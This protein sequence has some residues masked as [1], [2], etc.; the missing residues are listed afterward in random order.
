MANGLLTEYGDYTEKGEYRYMI[1][2]ANTPGERRTDFTYDARYF[3]LP[4]AVAEPSILSGSVKL[5]TYT[6]DDSGNRTSETIAGFRPDGTPVARMTTWKYGGPNPGDCPE[7]EAPF[8]QLCEIDGPRADVS[9]ITKYRYW[10]FDPN[11]QTHSTDDGRLKEVEDANGILIRHDIHYTPTGKIW[12]ESDANN[13]MTGYEYYPGNDRLK[14]MSVFGSG[15]T[16]YTEWTYLATGEVET[17]TTAHGSSDATTVTFSYD[18]ARRLVRVTNAMG[19]YIKYTLDTEGNV[20]KEEIFDANGTPADELDDVLTKVLTRVFDDYNRPDLLKLGD[21]PVN[22]LEV[23]DPFNDADGTVDYSTNGNGITT[24]YSYDALKRLLASTQDLNGTDP[25]TANARTQYDYDVADRLTEVMDPNNGTTTYQYDDLGNLISTTSPDTGVTNYT[26]DEAGNVKSKTTA[27]GTP[28]ALTLNYSYDAM[29]RLQNV[30]APDPRE[31]ITYT[32]DN[33]PNGAGRLCAVTNGASTVSYS[34]DSFGNVATHQGMS[35][36]YDLASR[37]RT[38]TYPSGAAVTYGYDP[39]GQISSV[40]LNIN[41]QAQSLASNITY[42]PFGGIETLTYGN[43]LALT[44]Q[45][46]TA[47]RLTRQSIPGIM[48]LDYPLYDGNGNLIQ[49][50]DST[51][52]PGVIST[53]GYDALDRLDA[54]SGPFASGWGYGYD[55]NGNRKQ[56]NEAVSIALDYEPNSNRLDVMGGADVIL[57]VAGNTLGIGGWS[58]TYTPHYRLASAS[59][60]AVVVATYA[61]NGLGQRVTKTRAG[62]GP[63]R[64][65]Y[66]LEGAL[67]AETDVAGTALKEYVYLN[68]APLAL[69][70]YDQDGDGVYQSAEWVLDPGR[71]WQQPAR[72]RCRRLRQSLRCRFQSE[73]GYQYN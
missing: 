42:S 53:F 18:D 49:R 19:N 72:R 10:P 41:G 29:N 31:N 15:G 16:Q 70:D 17:I 55:K 48:A 20:E 12:H 34:Y 64:F 6:Y 8:H 4:A 66:G 44:Q 35:Y 7:S 71:R 54:A 69:I 60:N 25:A 56:A 57:D 37:V 62:A 28:E 65:V 9:D 43:S 33:C 23:V 63:V 3:N 26:Y 40:D 68:G 5:T 1:E 27:A 24:H 45:R 36:T 2:A 47:Y 59:V 22:P 13:V 51:I 14:R 11:A 46:D 52:A 61:Y 73:R 32:Y 21:D 38:I 39:A 50:D 30:T 58:Y 67:L